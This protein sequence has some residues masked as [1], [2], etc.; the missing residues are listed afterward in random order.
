MPLA[1]G[2]SLHDVDVVLHTVVHVDPACGRRSTTYEM[3][4]APPTDAADHESE[5]VPAAT[6]PLG[7]PGAVSAP[8]LAPALP[9]P[10]PEK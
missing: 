1:P 3:V 6:D 9:V 8:T 7:F 2:V 10:D 4:P 5:T